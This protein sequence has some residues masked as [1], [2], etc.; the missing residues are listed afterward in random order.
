MAITLVPMDLHTGCFGL[1]T[2]GLR[3]LHSHI[4]H[5]CS[6]F[7]CLHKILSVSEALLCHWTVE[8]VL[9][10]DLFLTAGL[11]SQIVLLKML[12]N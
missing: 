9:E 2:E 11:Y 5:H 4:H 7:R 6:S 1:D 12:F 8:Y 3:Y 10:P